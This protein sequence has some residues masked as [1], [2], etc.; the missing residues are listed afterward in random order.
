MIFHPPS[1]PI[2]ISFKWLVPAFLVIISW[3]GLTIGCG[4]SDLTPSVVLYVSADE[5]LARQIIAVFEKETGI[6]VDILGDSE[7]KKTTG[8][9]ERLRAERDNPKADVF[10]SSE[11]FMTI[12]LAEEGV[13]AAHHSTVTEH[14]PAGYR[15]LAGKWY[16]LANRA[17]VVVYAEDRIPLSELPTTWMELADP[18]WKGRLVM[19]DP[20]FGTTG[21]HL[22]VMKWYWDRESGQEMY[23]SF[24]RG[25]AANGIQLLP[26]GNAAVVDAVARGE[27]DLGLTDTDDVWAAQAGGLKVGVIYPRHKASTG[28]NDSGGGTL[29]IPNTVALISGGPHPKEAGQLIDFLLSERVERMLAE[30]LSHN[31]PVHSS[32]AEAFP[33]YAVENPL[34]VDYVDAA[35]MRVDAVE[36]AMRILTGGGTERGSE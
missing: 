17:R 32:L 6:R 9:V 15:D 7:L 34:K 1:S 35:G 30:S 33:E 20:R 31:I 29:L 12:A 8:L 3:L 22:G 21:G 24:L 13:L 5:H 25:L 2:K 10:W 19:A 14:W 18:K 27:A 11:V 28:E 4:H 26:G 16:G 36:E 23:T